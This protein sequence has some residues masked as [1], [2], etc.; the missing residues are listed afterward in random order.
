[1]EVGALTS[2]ESDGWQELSPQQVEPCARSS[3]AWAKAEVRVASRSPLPRRPTAAA[4]RA[5][6][7]EVRASKGSAGGAT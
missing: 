6:A 7:R 1:M 3:R 4:A 2:E 5:R